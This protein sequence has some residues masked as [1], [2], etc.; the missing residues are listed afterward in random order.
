[1]SRED[2]E[3]AARCAALDGPAGSGGMANGLRLRSDVVDTTLFDIMSATDAMFGGVGVSQPFETSV[4]VYS[5]ICNI[6]QSIA[7][8]PVRLFTG[9]DDPVWD[10]EYL[11]LM[12]QPNP[13]QTGEELV[14]AFLTHKEIDGIAYLVE[15][16]FELGVR[17]ARRQILVASKSEIE[18]IENAGA[19]L[20][21]RYTPLDGGRTRMLT[22]DQV[23]AS[24]HYHPRKRL[25]GL[26][27]AR[28][29]R[30]AI[31]GHSGALALFRNAVKNGAELGAVFTTDKDLSESQHADA[32]KVI[33][34]RYSGPENANKPLLLSGGIKVDR[35]SQGMSDINWL[36]GM[37]VSATIIATAY[38]VPPLFVNLMDQAQ[39]N[40]APAQME[41]FWTMNG[42]PAK[43][44][45]ESALNRIVLRSERENF[46]FALDTSDIQV[47]KLQQIAFVEQAFKLTQSGVARNEINDRFDL[48]F[49]N[50]PWG[51]VPLVEAGKIP[52][53]VLVEEAQ[54]ALAG[55]NTPEGQ[56]P[57]DAAANDK[58]AAEDAE[59]LEPDEG[60]KAD[61]TD[62][63]IRG[64][65]DAAQ[66][67]TRAAGKAAAWLKWWRSWLGLR[68]GTQT[69]M[70]RFFRRQA[71]ETVARLREA[72]GDE[73]K[74]VALAALI[75][76]ALE[77]TDDA[78]RRLVAQAPVDGDTLRADADEIV[79]RVLFD[80]AEENGKLTA[81]LKPQIADGAEL[82]GKQVADEVAGGF[83]F[84]IDAP[85]VRAHIEQQAIRIT[86]INQVTRERVRRVLL[87]GLDGGDSLTELAESIG[88]AMGS[89]H[90]SR[91][92]LIAQTEMHQAINAGRK[93]AITQTGLLKS[94]LTSGK[95][96]KT[97]TNPNGVVR[98]AHKWAE[99]VSATGIDA[100]AEFVLIDEDGNKE[101]AQQPGDPKLS[102]ANTINCSCT[103]VAKA[104]SKSASAALNRV[105]EYTYERMLK[106]RG[107]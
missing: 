78:W 55:E 13:E 40:S 73:A 85:D 16:D 90:A 92:Y 82:G 41:L 54:A 87:N 36:E 21:Y 97:K 93:S 43:R 61:A 67:V 100:D 26:S 70:R 24:R 72:L 11:D 34:L 84:N 33:R 7:G 76:R 83:S 5:A 12:Q 69:V 9:R 75:G 86:R 80:L 107:R 49:E 79:E 63:L 102:P 74:A 18:P 91:S 51:S 62:Q 106:E 89:A 64:A 14:E 39:Y 17:G 1:L 59:A 81:V 48:G 45:V 71:Q 8:L 38:R 37:G 6:A 105:G 57:G 25:E 3:F 68:R 50:P 47:L 53:D 30:L 60:E 10:H 52:M 56:A 19:L 28:V 42:L 66:G 32:L 29:A 44:R 31:E 20:G 104:A 35:G 46:Y 4:Y 22:L 99:R 95:P 98:P 103:L 27:G 101:T 88:R 96:V 15:P 58:P 94:W 23:V 2:A 65:I 77:C